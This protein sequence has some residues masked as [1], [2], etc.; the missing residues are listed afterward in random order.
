MTRVAINTSTVL[1]TLTGLAIVWQF[2]GAALIF[3]MSLAL[4]A[5]VRPAIEYFMRRG[6]PGRWP[7]R[8][9]TCRCSA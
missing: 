8:R 5:A 7:S 1:A 6:I 3:C 9:L 4:A 2:R